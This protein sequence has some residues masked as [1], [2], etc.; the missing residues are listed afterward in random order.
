MC[1]I[2]GIVYGNTNPKISE[3]VQM[4]KAIKHR[5]PDDE[6][7]LKFQ[8]TILGHVRL[9]IQD[10]SDKGKQPMSND[11]RYWIIYNGEIYNF[12]EIKKELQSLG[13]KFF[14]KTD[15]EVI[16][17]SYK[18]WGVKS[19]DK[20][21]GM[22]AF[23][24]LDKKK[25][26]LIL[27]RDRYGVKPCYYYFNKKKFIF[28]SEIKGIYSSNSDINFDQN[29]IIYSEKYLEGVSSTNF[30][31]VYTV[32]PGSYFK[33]DI[34]KLT[35][36]KLRWWYGLKNIPEININ[37]RQSKEKLKDLLFE[38]TNL[39][40]V[41]DVKISNSLSG[42]IDSA[43]I[44]S[45]L[46]KLDHNEKVD[47]NPFIYQGDNITFDQAIDL[48]KFYNRQPKIINKVET[49]FI[50]LSD[51]LSS[52]E[53]PQTYF[54]QLEIYKKQK[55]NN[56]KISIDG[57]GADECLGGYSKDLQL[58]PMFYQ[59]SIIGI[60][61]SLSNIENIEYTNKIIKN[62]KFIEN[63][64]GYNIDLKKIF[65]DEEYFKNKR[66]S[67]NK[68]INSKKINMLSDNLNEDLNELKYFNLPFQILYFHAN[69]G[70]MQWLLNKW[71]KASMASSI[72][73]RSPYLDW[74]FFQFALALPAEYKFNLGKNKYILREA[75]KNLLPKS[76]N[77]DFR[78]QG[79]KTTKY[80][81]KELDIK[82]IEEGIN[83]KTFKEEK[84]W[85]S[86]KII[87]DF[88]ALKTANN[89][90]EKNKIWKIFC[91]YSLK[92]GFNKI[93]SESKKINKNYKENFNLLTE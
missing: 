62:Y 7:V 51:S 36:S 86:K 71:D 42:G 59:N 78:K 33:I 38:A 80:K 87:S 70:H 12:K 64:K 20:F 31:N 89:Q 32:P 17:N 53:I 57:H 45:I 84:S 76:I 23:A 8:N 58:F 55:A 2:N 15:T 75:F 13:H 63:L 18:E 26:E 30:E 37:F 82:L 54:N 93:K 91:L 34:Q 9:S 69:Y 67:F 25:S 65:Y 1:G 28:S 41:S 61:Q 85:D 90:K 56:F 48:T 22:W 77:E 73:I 50:N 27:S 44:F 88:Y 10:L 49:N 6:G 5:G 35:I 19:F 16:L 79:L 60:Y 46:N 72:E 92:E 4:N 47:L 14:S 11:E 40:L 83:Q 74:N 66:K 52:I 39:R 29:K 21:N 43:I 3:I 24:I 81:D 68:Y